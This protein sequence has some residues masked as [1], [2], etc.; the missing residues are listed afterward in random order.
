ML[1]DSRRIEVIDD[2][3]AAALRRLSPQ[4]RLRMANV[5]VVQARG[6]IAVRVRSLHPDWD[7]SQVAAEVRRRMS[8]GSH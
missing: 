6:M 2:A 7:E 5:M 8:R 1:F 3:T 4:E